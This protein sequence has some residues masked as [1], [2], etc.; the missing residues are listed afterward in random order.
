MDQL[1]NRNQP[2]APSVVLGP[3]CGTGD[4]SRRLAPLY[5]EQEKRNNLINAQKANHHSHS[6]PH[7]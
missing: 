6:R 4:I 7:L 2:Y 3:G 1:D 5:S